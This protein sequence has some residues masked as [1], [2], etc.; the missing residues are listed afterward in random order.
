MMKVVISVCG[1]NSQVMSSLPALEAGFT[2]FKNKVD[3]LEQVINAQIAHHK[4]IAKEKQGLKQELVKTG[5][6]IAKAVMAYAFKTNQLKLEAEVNYGPAEMM[7]ARDELLVKIAENILAKATE[8]LGNIAG[9]GIDQNSLDAFGSLIEEFNTAGPGP[10][11]ARSI[12]RMNTLKL[13]Q[14]TKEAGLILRKQLDRLVALLPEEHADFRSVYFNARE[15]VN[16]RGK[17]RN[18]AP[19]G[20]QGSLEGCVTAEFD[21]SPVEDALVLIEGTELSAETDEDGEFYFEQVPA[22]SYTL[23]VMAETYADTV[24]PEVQIIDNTEAEVDV[25]MRA[26]TE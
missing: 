19:E 4:G 22:G 18:G 26:E 13:D 15:I 5:S 23:R 25:V 20:G 2:G 8:N 7:R 12:R 16:Y 6:L 10:R 3:E 1:S 11:E 14:L 24:V 17:R 21:G 9:Y